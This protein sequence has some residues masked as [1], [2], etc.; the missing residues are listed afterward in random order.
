[1]FK[2]HQGPEQRTDSSPAHLQS[3]SAGSSRLQRPESS[4]EFDSPQGSDNHSNASG[5][6]PDGRRGM[7]R[8]NHSLL[9]PNSSPAAKSLLTPAHKS[10]HLPTPQ[11]PGNLSLSLGLSDGSP[12]RQGSSSGRA[13]AST[14]KLRDLSQSERGALPNE[15]FPTPESSPMYARR[16]RSSNNAST[17]PPR[18]PRPN[19][20][21]SR[22][23]FQAS[24]TLSTAS[25]PT[26]PP[27]RSRDVSP[28][29]RSSLSSP[30][31]D[32][33]AQLTPAHNHEGPPSRRS[34]SHISSPE[35]SPMVVDDMFS[36]VPSTS[37]IKSTPSLKA[38]VPTRP[39]S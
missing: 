25:A 10:S 6:T 16:P 4:H 14:T 21:S 12:V 15:S 5:R 24:A 9:T 7:A 18:T 22:F 30:F 1:M 23:M 27:P 17:S 31:V 13:S 38:P 34:R 26:T 33:S 36:P 19:S 29:L 20:S 35:T 28:P 2:A 39:L 11:S 37:T 3:P 8:R 32:R